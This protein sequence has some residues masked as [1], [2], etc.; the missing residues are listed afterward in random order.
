VLAEQLVL[1]IARYYLYMMPN[2]EVPGVWTWQLYAG[3]L[4]LLKGY[5]DRVL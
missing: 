1:A 3:A 4:G 2:R 5:L